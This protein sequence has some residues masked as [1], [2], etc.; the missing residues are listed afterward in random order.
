MALVSDDPVTG[1]DIVL[2]GGRVAFDDGTTF[3][4]V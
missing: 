3:E 1:V 4:G 2:D